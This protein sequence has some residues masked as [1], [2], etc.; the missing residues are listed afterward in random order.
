MTDSRARHR[1]ER[2]V[3]LVLVL[4]KLGTHLAFGYVDH[5]PMVPWVAGMVYFFTDEGK[6][7]RLFGAPRRG[8]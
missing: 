7:Y 3:L 1:R 5:A 6:R 2:Q 4:F 8:T